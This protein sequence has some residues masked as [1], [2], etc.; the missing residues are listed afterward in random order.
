MRGSDAPQ[1]KLLFDRFWV[2][3]QPREPQEKFRVV[4]VSGREPFG[5]FVDRTPW[6]G[7]FELFHYHMVPHKDGVIDCIFGH[8]Q[9]RQ[10]LSYTARPC[11]ENGFD[12]CLE[13]SGTSR[14][15]KRYYSKKEWGAHSPAE[16][17]AIA[18]QLVP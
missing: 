7:A 11:H 4:F 13:L 12:Y 2:D 16:A 8:T 3:H 6:T 10:Q 5:Q 15:V 1:P 18:A 9:E 17:D 14:G